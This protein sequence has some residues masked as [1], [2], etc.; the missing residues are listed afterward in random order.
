MIIVFSEATNLSTAVTARN[1]RKP[2]VRKTAVTASATARRMQ[3]MN[4]NSPAIKRKVVRM[5]LVTAYL[6]SLSV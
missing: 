2:N 6:H 4:A 3:Q 1:S 5:I